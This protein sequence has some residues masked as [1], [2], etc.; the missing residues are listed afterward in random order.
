M[1]IDL[2]SDTV[3]KPSKEMLEAMLNAKVGD[4]VFA[5]DETVN[6]LEEKAAQLFN[7][8]AGIFC[9]SGTM[10]NQIAI[11]LHTQALDEVICH[12]DSHI[13]KYEV[14][15]YAY[16]SAVSIKLLDGE[17][18]KITATQVKESVHADYDWLPNSKLVVL[19]NT[20]NRGGGSIYPLAQMQ[21]IKDV[22]TKHDLKLHL[23]GAR[24]FNAIV[25]SD[26]SSNDLGAIFDSI[27]I[28]LSKGLGCPVGTVLVGDKTFIKKARKVRKVL[29]GGMRQVGFLAA[30]GIYALDKNIQRLQDD[31]QNA[32][33]IGQVLKSLPYIE[34]VLNPE[35]N[36]LIFELNKEIKGDAFIQKLEKQNIKAIE[37]GPQMIR[38]VTHLDITKEMCN[39]VIDCVQSI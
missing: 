26:Y 2:R 33:E 19:E 6:K 29:G 8:E 36:I 12:K 4:D 28:C 17:R 27:S 22:C 20:V 35:S 16:H 39:K 23:D 5:E 18:G 14:G 11:K 7:K 10:A 3:T 38:F 31:H 9:P 24:V 37:F 30:A 21:A 25:E 1:I 15:G 34:K 32:K 13:Y